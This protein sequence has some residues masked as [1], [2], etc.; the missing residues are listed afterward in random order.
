MAYGQTSAIVLGYDG[1]RVELIDQDAIDDG[2]SHFVVVLGFG[3]DIAWVS[4]ERLAT[5]TFRG[6]LAVIKL[7]PEFLLKSDRPHASHPNP[8]TSPQF[9]ASRA[10][11]LSRVTRIDY[12]L[13]GCFCRSKSEITS[14]FQE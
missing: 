9:P 10:R 8:F 5:R 11:C 12:R 4:S 1:G 2:S 3:F 7:P 14:A 13:G 6:V